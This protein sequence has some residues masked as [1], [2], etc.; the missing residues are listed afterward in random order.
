MEVKDL[1]EHLRPDKL[2]EFKP[3]HFWVNKKDPAKKMTLADSFVDEVMREQHIKFHPEI[4]H[5]IPFGDGKLCV[6]ASVEVWKSGNESPI[7]DKVKAFASVT[8]MPRPGGQTHYAQLAITRA[9]KTA[10]I[11]LLGISDHDIELIISA[12]GIDQKMVPSS[13]RGNEAEVEEVA[14]LPEVVEPDIDL[15]LGL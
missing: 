1:P 15:N 7:L 8:E 14:S 4:S 3:Y 2:L 9:L 11:R 13:L 5:V 6:V 12:Y 10:V